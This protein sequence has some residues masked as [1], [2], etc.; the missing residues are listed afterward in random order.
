MVSSAL[1]LCEH[2]ISQTT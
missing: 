2:Q 1:I